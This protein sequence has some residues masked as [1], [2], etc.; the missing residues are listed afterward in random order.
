MMDARRQRFVVNPSRDCRCSRDNRANISSGALP[1]ISYLDLEKV[2]REA[3]E[4]NQRQ[5]PSVA[6]TI[7]APT[8]LSPS[9]MYS[10]PPPPYSYPSSTTASSIS[11][12]NGYISPPESRRTSDD[13]KEPPQ[14]PQAPPIPSLQSLPSIHEAL[15]GDQPLPYTSVAPPANLA[16]SLPTAPTQ[17]PTIH[18]PRPQP[19]KNG[20]E[21]H[22]PYPST[23][24]PRANYTSSQ[25]SERLSNL[26][27]SHLSSE[28]KAHPFTSI[29]R[30][31]PAP[32]SAP[33]KPYTSPVSRHIYSPRMS[34]LDRLSPPN[35]QSTHSST[36]MQSQAPRT[37]YQPAYSYPPSAP[38]QTAHSHH[39]YQQPAWR[40]DGS[41]IDR[42]EEMRKAAPRGSPIS[43]HQYGESVKRHLDIFDLETSLN[44]V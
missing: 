1:S 39:Y 27:H 36:S 24:L 13:D 21:S 11:G 16:Q 28:D 4:Y 42:A 25:A 12:L 2:K 6:M 41:E 17:S 38:N 22:G 3:S 7:P 34:H 31:E 33:P 30:Q 35:T 37:P 20:I 14:P 8:I 29:N 9:T 44:E 19:E 23:Q 32:L 15:G 43:G 18:I 5:L 40:A 26:P 10:G